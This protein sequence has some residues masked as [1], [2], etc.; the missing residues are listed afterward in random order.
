[1]ANNYFAF[2]QF[3]IYQ[4]KCAMKV[5]TDACIFG[6]VLPKMNNGKAL[7]IGT[8][9]GLLSLMFAQKN[10]SCNIDTIEIENDAFEQAKNNIASSIFNH[11]INIINGDI[12]CYSSENKYQLIFCNPPFY[13][14]DLKSNNDA[15][16]IAMHTSLLSYDSL[17]NA[18]VNLLDIDGTFAILIPYKLERQIIDNAFSSGL[19]ANSIIRL[20]QTENHSYFRSIIFFNKQI[21]TV[22]ESALI[23][24]IQNEYSKEFIELLK[25]YYLYL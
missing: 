21:N 2:K 25:D 5:C 23:I 11:R 17:M 24:K 20:Q 8:G 3:T 19:F 22:K 18:V 10:T 12:R 4:D 1:M 6:A 14:N 16:N 15:K 13:E 9:T 7:D